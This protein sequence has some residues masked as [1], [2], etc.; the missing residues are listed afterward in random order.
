MRTLAMTGMVTASTI[1]LIICGS[2]WYS[3]QSPHVSEDRRNHNDTDHSSDAAVGPDVSRNTL[4]RHDGAGA[5][6]LG[7]ACLRS[8]GAEHAQVNDGTSSM[9]SLKVA[10]LFRIDDIHDDAALFEIKEAAQDQTSKTS[11]P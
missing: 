4:E 3:G 7:Y 2:L 10:H 1:C 6:F 9:V 8:D 5:G 11:G